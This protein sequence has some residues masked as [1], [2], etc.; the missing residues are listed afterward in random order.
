MTA[1]KNHNE[2]NEVTLVFF[3]LVTEAV[4]KFDCNKVQSTIA[5]LPYTH[6]QQYSGLQYKLNAEAATKKQWLCSNEQG[7]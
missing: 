2:V 5:R 6:F 3:S 1:I 4:T 7:R